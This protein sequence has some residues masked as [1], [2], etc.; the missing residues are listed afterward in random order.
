MMR[1][2][3]RAFDAATVKDEL[4]LFVISFVLLCLFLKYRSFG[5]ERARVA[6]KNKVTL[7]YQFVFVFFFF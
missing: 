6:T 7:Y 5:G 2:D 4:V 3:L 1:S